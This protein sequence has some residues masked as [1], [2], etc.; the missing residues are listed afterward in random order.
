M[1]LGSLYFYWSQCFKFEYVDDDGDD[2]DKDYSDY[3]RKVWHKSVKV[4]EQKYD[5]GP[6]SPLIFIGGFPRSGTTLMRAMLDA[7][8]DVR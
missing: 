6:L 1:T 2:T 5:Y 7:H 8:P 3:T 4:G